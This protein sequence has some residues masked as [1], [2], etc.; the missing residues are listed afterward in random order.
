MHN[1]DNGQ[2]ANIWDIATVKFPKIGYCVISRNQPSL[3]CEI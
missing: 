1:F 3:Q 2:I